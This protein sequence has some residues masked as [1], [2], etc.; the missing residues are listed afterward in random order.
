[1]C[2]YDHSTYLKNPKIKFL[3]TELLRE[4]EGKLAVNHIVKYYIDIDR[5]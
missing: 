2:K 5:D 3:I 1:M 4:K